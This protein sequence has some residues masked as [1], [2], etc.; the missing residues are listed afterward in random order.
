M[1]IRVPRVMTLPA[2]RFDAAAEKTGHGSLEARRVALMRS[3][4]LESLARQ[5]E[6]ADPA[7]EIRRRTVERPVNLIKNGD[8]ASKDGW[9]KSV[10]W[11][12]SEL[13]FENKVTGRASVRIT[14]DSVPHPE[15][16]VQGDFA[17]RLNVKK[18]RTYRISYFIKIK[19]VIPYGSQSPH[20]MG[21]GLC[22][23][24]ADGDY[25]ERH[26]AKHPRPYMQGDCGWN[27]QRFVFSPPVDSP[28][29]WLQFRLE[30]SL[31]TMWVDG[32]LLEDITET[33][34]QRKVEQ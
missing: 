32:I 15:K 26:Y 17:T 7:A 3:E 6:E 5:S 11:G 18:G 9:R 27:I 14:S 12:T 29:A 16:N 31:G 28:S 22:L 33:T 8:F 23:W 34:R 24:Y 30:D 20:Q 4:L 13:D 2:Y 19:N 21:A 1:A 25:P 10:S